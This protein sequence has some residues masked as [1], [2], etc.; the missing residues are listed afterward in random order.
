MRPKRARTCRQD[1][2][3]ANQDPTR[4]AAG[5]LRPDSAILPW[6][7]GRPGCAPVHRPAPDGVAVAGLEPLDGIEPPAYSLRGS[8]SGQLS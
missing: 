7:R 2:P 3:W 5:R 8:R 4:V 6:S 1:P